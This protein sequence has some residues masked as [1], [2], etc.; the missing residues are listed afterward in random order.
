MPQEWINFYS[1]EGENHQT[2]NVPL[3]FG[4]GRDVKFTWDGTDFDILAGTDDSVIKFGDGSESFDIQILGNIPTA[5]L[6]WDASANDLVAR[7]PVRPGG[8]NALPRRLELRWVGGQRGKP[9]INADIQNATESTRMITDPDLEVQGTNASSDDVTYY[10][11]GGI[12]LQTDGA[13]GDEVILVPHQDTNQSAWKQVTWG[14]DKQ[15]HWE[16]HILTGAAITNMIIWA[17]LKLTSTEVKVTDND[18]AFFRYENAVNGGKWEAVS[19]INGTDDAADSGVT[20]AVNTEYH[21]KVT[22][23]SS[24]VARFYINGALVETSGAL[25]DATDLVPFIGVANDGGTGAKDLYVFGQAIS[26]VVG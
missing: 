9:G 18:Q 15:V 7:G 25:K 3:I 19:S 8:F 10:A 14:T 4:D 20:V 12:H 6:E 5:Y 23:D 17:G 11:E 22:I 1:Q 21:L 26:R 24:R 2:D 16:A 13:D